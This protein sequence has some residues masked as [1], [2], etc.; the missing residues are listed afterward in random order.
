LYIQHEFEPA[1]PAE[2]NQECL[3]KL[4]E[5][6]G[7]LIM[8]G[9][10]YGS[11]DGGVSITHMEF[12]TARDESKPL[13]VFIKGSRETTREDEVKILLKEIDATGVKYNDLPT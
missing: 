13:F 7:V 5:C 4:R 6:N 9:A 3:A 11:R 12:R 2:S 1:S 10:T 8:I